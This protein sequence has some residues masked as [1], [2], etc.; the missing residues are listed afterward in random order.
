MG[1][2]LLNTPIDSRRSKLFLIGSR[3]N[4][5]RE[6]TIWLDL[7]QIHRHK[8]ILV[9]SR[10]ILVKPSWY[11]LRIKQRERESMGRW[12]KKV[13]TGNG[14]K[15]SDGEEISLCFCSTDQV[16][17]TCSL[18][19]IDANPSFPPKQNKNNKLWI[20]DTELQSDPSSYWL[21]IRKPLRNS[22]TCYTLVLVHINPPSLKRT[23]P[24]RM[25]S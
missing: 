3:S 7:D 22:H 18:C 5:P 21:R 11:V 8:V 24:S 20:K 12:K 6:I 25:T 10:L 2:I 13:G 17:Y 4:P 19:R 23:L 14:E 1:W 16:N 15:M 9:G